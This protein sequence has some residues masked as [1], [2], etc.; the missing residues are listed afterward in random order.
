MIS[1]TTISAKVS[2]AQAL[3]ESL[4]AHGVTHVFCVPGE[5]YLAVLDAL[6][7]VRDQITV[8]ACRH[9]AAAANM[10]VAH[11]KLTGRPGVAMVT[12]GPGATHASIG[13][14][15]ARQDS[16]PMV[17]FVGQVSTEDL[18]REAFQELDYPAVFGTLAKS[19]VQV[20]RAERMGEFVSRAFATAAQGRMG[21]VV[22]AL[23]EDVL[24]EEVRRPVLATP[25]RA[26]ATLPSEFIAELDLRLQQSLRPLLILGGSGWTAQAAAHLAQAAVNAGVPIALSFR[27][28]DLID[29]RHP[30]YAGDLGLGPNPKLVERVKAADLIIAIGARLGENPTQGYSLFTLEE[31]AAKLIH[32]HPDPQELGRVW[33][34]SL[35]AVANV[36]QAALVLGAMPPGPRARP[37]DWLTDAHADLEAFV[38][39]VSVVGKVNL[40][41]VFAHLADALP[42][43]AIV[44]N[45]AGN[46][47][48]WLH[49]F[50]RH[51]R[52]GTQ[53][54]PT[55]GAM[56]FGFPAGIGAKIVN[57]DR[58]VVT[59]SGD[60]DF[61]MCAQELA[62]AVQYGANIVALVVDNGAY[63]TIRMHQERDFPG[64][65]I[66]TDLANPDFVAFAESFGAH[67][68]RVEETA[69]F[70]AAL[71]RARA[72]GRPALIHLVTDLRDISPGRVLAL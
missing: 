50:Y 34:A 62:T 13:V 41:E 48:A 67:A 58:E 2:G 43:D 54:A 68:E 44:A 66:A 57:P 70:P 35:A 72:A 47:A 52:F 3:V 59:V 42:D 45:G 30:A 24:R 46:F 4:V 21:P 6:Y 22:V 28:K 20:D 8:I 37:S 65:P 26:V 53:L 63:G 29:N 56:G 69:R 60:G 10:A 31:T 7:D 32:V 71:E 49:R 64:R 51:R 27:R 16:A 25:S 36:E 12:R 11:G 15:T 19:A 1:D 38:Q 55:S 14:H 39:P 61:M 17:L 33:P 5:S 23:P 9:E 40:S 18:G